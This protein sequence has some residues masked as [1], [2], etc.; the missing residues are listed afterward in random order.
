MA[1]AISFTYWDECVDA[2]DMEE[3]WNQPEVK[4]EWIAAGETQGQRVH[5]SR[6]PDG[7]TY[8][9]Q[10]EMRAVAEIITRRH[11]HSQIDPD[12]I[13]AIAELGSDRQPLTM[14]YD[15]KTKLTTIGIMQIAPKTAEWLVRECNLALYPVE[16]DPDI[17]YR[18]FVSVYFGAAYLKWLSNIDNIKRTEE[19]IVRAYKGGTKKAT[20]KST[21]PYWQR[22]LSVKESFPSRKHSDGPTPTQAPH[23]PASS[24]PAAVPYSCANLYWDSR[25]SSE[26]MELM[27]NNPEVSKEWKRSKETRGQVRFSHDKEK[28]PYL[29][30]IELKAAAEIIISKYFSTRGIKPVILCA[31]A[32]IISMRYV[33]G[34]EGQPGIMG[35]DY[36]TAFW[37]YAEV[38]NRAYRV[39][40]E[41][42]LTKPF[43]SLYFGAAYLAWLSEYKG[44]ERSLQ[45]IVQAY[46]SGPKNAKEELGHMWLKFEQI[47]SSYETTITIN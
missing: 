7:Q 13:C 47:L 20:H 29:S 26:D 19:Y 41:K 34:I 28:K 39:D 9:T 36:S 37:L 14:R 1:M 15:K 23:A 30:R 27:W 42:D 16:E 38:G 4:K 5:L 18:P 22:Y 2:K 31:L 32:E 44:R 46:L 17:L 12:M 24:T 40:Y 11:F 25:V 8:L 21:L 3:M 43:V 10:T 35:I 6:D 45:F 33:D